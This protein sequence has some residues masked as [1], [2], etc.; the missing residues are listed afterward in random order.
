MASQPLP[1]RQKPWWLAIE[2]I[3]HQ[4]LEQILDSAEGSSRLTSCG[5]PEG[6]AFLRATRGD[7]ISSLS[8]AIFVAAV[9]YRLGLQ[10]MPSMTCQLKTKDQQRLCN[11]RADPLGH[12]AVIC[13][14]GGAPYAAHSN[15]CHIL[16]QAAIQA[17]YQAKREQV[18]P[19]LASAKCMSPQLDIEGWGLHG[20]PR[21][22]VDFTIRHP[23]ASRYAAGRSST[24]AATDEKLAHYQPR[25]GLQVQVAALE[26]YGKHGAGLRTLLE[27]MADQARQRDVAMGAKPGRWLKRWRAQLSHTAAACVGRAIQQAATP[28]TQA[29]TCT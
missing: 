24:A 11:E 25:G 8:D 14:V 4:H 29:A 27:G 12:H 15:G 9:K 1:K 18:V 28:S 5:G 23:A 17:G 2:R 20:Q 3:R 6:G 16:Q 21:L 10:T 22:L 7:G 26:V 19:E 13:K